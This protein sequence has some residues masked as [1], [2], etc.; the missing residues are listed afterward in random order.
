TAMPERRVV[1]L[2]FFAISGVGNRCPHKKRFLPSDFPRHPAQKAE[3]FSSAAARW[4][5]MRL[6]GKRQRVEVAL[7]G[8]TGAPALRARRHRGRRGWRWAFSAWLS[9]C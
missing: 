6:T 2:E 5:R 4:G 7:L 1:R 3:A 9:Y 8:R